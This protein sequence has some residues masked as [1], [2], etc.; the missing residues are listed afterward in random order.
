MEP[1]RG[2]LCGSHVL[3]SKLRLQLGDPLCFGFPAGMPDGWARAG[4]SRG[5]LWAWQRVHRRICQKLEFLGT[6][7]LPSQKHTRGMGFRLWV[8]EGASGSE[9]WGCKAFLWARRTPRS[10][11]EPF[12]P[13]LRMQLQLDLERWHLI[14][15]RSTTG[16]EPRPHK[17]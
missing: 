12:M 1:S 13:P 7:D 8:T 11:P 3:S 5:W 9:S 4:F 14:Q 6:L 16:H 15:V 17:A 2:A 10:L